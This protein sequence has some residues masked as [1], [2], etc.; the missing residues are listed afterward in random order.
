MTVFVSTIKKDDIFVEQAD[1]GLLIEPNIL[2]RPKVTRKEPTLENTFYSSSIDVS[3][4]VL[5]ITGSYNQ[6]SSIT[7]YDS[8]TGKIN[9]YS[10][11]TGSSVVSSNGTNL[12]KEAWWF[13]SKRFFYG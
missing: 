13:R 10:Y 4:R 5:V 6:G 11:E 12:L 7:N 1:I 2:E 9:V 3:K 8:Y